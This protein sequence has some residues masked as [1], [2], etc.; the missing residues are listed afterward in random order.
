M[1]SHPNV[2]KILDVVETNNHLNIIMEYLDGISLNN[3][4]K[5]QPNHRAPENHCKAIIRALTE[6]LDY[7]HQRQISHRDIKL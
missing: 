6:A 2:V 5:S 3:Y 4:L 1:L 7:L